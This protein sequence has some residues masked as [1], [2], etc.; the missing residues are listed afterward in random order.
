MP[1]AA[2]RQTR[3]PVSRLS[4]RALR[5][6]LLLPGPHALDPHCPGVDRQPEPARGV[7]ATAADAIHDLRNYCS[8]CFRESAAEHGRLPATIL[9]ELLEPDVFCRKEGRPRIAEALR[10]VSDAMNFSVAR[11]APFAC[12]RPRCTLSPQHQNR[13]G[14]A[15]P[16]AQ[17]RPLSAV[18]RVDARHHGRCLA[19]RP[20]GETRPTFEKTRSRASRASTADSLP[21]STKRGADDDASARD[22]S[23]CGKSEYIVS[24]KNVFKPVY[25]SRGS[26]DWRVGLNEHLDDAGGGENDAPA[27]DM[28]VA[29]GFTA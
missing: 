19:K 15:H 14:A 2:A 12:T 13:A 3:P 8:N 25:D 22:F 29:Y 20:R 21:R 7:Q 23:S 24:V 26:R 28:A 10:Q 6:P 4:A 1:N 11:F 17:P 27:K 18:R 16:H 5:A 9:P